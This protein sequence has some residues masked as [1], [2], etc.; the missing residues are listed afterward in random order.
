[1]GD[2]ILEQGCG[3]VDEERVVG[4]LPL[5]EPV[6]IG[7]GKRAGDGLVQRIGCDGFV[8]PTEDGARLKMLQQLSRLSAGLIGDVGILVG[9]RGLCCRGGRQRLFENVELTEHLPDGLEITQDLNTLVG[10]VATVFGTT[11]TSAALPWVLYAPLDLNGD[12]VINVADISLAVQLLEEPV[13]DEPV[14]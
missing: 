10:R 2:T 11:A 13:A 14:V 6:A 5:Q 1:M 3:P 4:A 9:L 7:A 12:G 8:Q